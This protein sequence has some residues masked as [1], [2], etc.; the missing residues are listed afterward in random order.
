MTQATL[1]KKIRGLEAELELLKRV[2]VQKPDFA[3]DDMN[4][5]KVRS[6]AKATRRK[7]Y[8]RRYGKNKT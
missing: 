8:Q 2:V 6:E 5:Q 3:I 4:W 1:K 7:L